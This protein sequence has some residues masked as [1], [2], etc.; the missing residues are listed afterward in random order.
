MSEEQDVI[1]VDLAPTPGVQGVAAFSVGDLREKSAQAIEN[2]MGAIHGMATKVMASI[3][4][5]KVSERPTKVEVAFGIKMTAEGDA[6]VAKV[7]AETA[8]TVTLTWE[9]KIED[10]PADKPQ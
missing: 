3:K 6:L 8:I 4:K 1:L 7:G 9:H 10:E 2:A 5:I